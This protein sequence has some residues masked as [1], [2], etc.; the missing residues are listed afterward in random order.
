MP[1]PFSPS[2]SL[3]SS[4]SSSVPFRYLSQFSPQ[5]TLSEAL[6]PGHEPPDSMVVFPLRPSLSRTALSTS[7]LFQLS[8]VRVQYAHQTKSLIKRDIISA[9][10]SSVSHTTSHGI[11]NLPMVDT[12]RHP[13]HYTTRHRKRNLP[14]C[15]FFPSPPPATSSQHTHASPHSSL[16]TG[17]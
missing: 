7:Y 1:L 13:A 9:K 5:Y 4:S 15:H 3:S 16:A 11:C 8:P 6:F 14:T 17:I 2:K 12:K 10:K